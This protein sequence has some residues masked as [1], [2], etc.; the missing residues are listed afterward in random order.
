VL[1][2]AEKIKASFEFGYMNRV[3]V[4]KYGKAIVFRQ[5]LKK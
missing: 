2:E 4:G 1:E 5:A 3:R